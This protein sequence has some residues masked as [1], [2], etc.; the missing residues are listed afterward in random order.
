[1]ASMVSLTDHPDLSYRT[2]EVIREAIV[3]GELAPGLRLTVV[4][5]AGRLGV[6]RSPVKDAL[7]R[8]S[9]EGL[10]EDV[11]RKGYFVCYLSAHDLTE[12]LEAGLLV[13]CAALD[14]GLTSLDAVSL[15]RLRGLVVGMEQLVDPEGRYLDYSAFMRLDAEFH[16]QV[17]G[18]SGNRRLADIYLSLRVHSYAARMHFLAELGHRRALPTLGEHRAIMAALGAR[19]V[20]GAKVALS[21][22]VRQVIASFAA[23][24]SSPAGVS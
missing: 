13:E 7:N 22:H 12:V 23:V 3:K 17:V 6:S 18:I 21:E 8:L 16:A 15:E 5:L 24:G 2:Y 9:G 11:P 10:V 1:M 19:D 14:K 4:D 20:A